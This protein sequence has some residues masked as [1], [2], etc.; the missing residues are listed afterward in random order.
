MVADKIWL[1]VMFGKIMEVKGKFLAAVS[2]FRSCP[3]FS[4]VLAQEVLS[5]CDLFVF[6]TPAIGRHFLIYYALNFVIFGMENIY[7]CTLYIVF[8]SGTLAY[9]R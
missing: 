9:T 6:S 5:R 2:F 4:S 7:P 3:L 1:Y 8:T